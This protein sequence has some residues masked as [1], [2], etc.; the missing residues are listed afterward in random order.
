MAAVSVDLVRRSRRFEM[1]EMVQLHLGVARYQ[2]GLGW[3]SF[4]NKIKDNS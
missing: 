2:S 3:Q 4:V 1:S